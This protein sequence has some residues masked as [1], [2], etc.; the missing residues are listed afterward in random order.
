MESTSPLEEKV[1]INNLD[2][3][4]KSLSYHKII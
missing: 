4:L 2:Q 3:L 1:G